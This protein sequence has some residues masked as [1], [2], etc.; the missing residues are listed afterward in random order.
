MSR[1]TYGTIKEVY[2]INGDSRISYRIVAYVDADVDGT[3]TII[4][5][6]RDVTPNREKIDNLV[7]LCN[8]LELSVVHLEDVVED[9]LDD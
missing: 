7:E 2:S 3:A 1:I 6:I 8:R 9:I 4:A 5:S